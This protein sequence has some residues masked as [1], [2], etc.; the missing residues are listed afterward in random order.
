[1]IDQETDVRH[2]CIILADNPGAFVELC[3]ISALERL[4]RTLQRL[5]LTNA[6]LLSATPE[7]I[8]QRLQDAS[9][10]RAKVALEIRPRGT[11]PVTV[12]DVLDAWPNDEE[13]ILL[14]RGDRVFDSRLLQLLDEH[15]STAALVDSALPADLEPLVA[16]AQNTSCGYF[17]GAARLSQQWAKSH[18][19]V[20]DETLCREIENGRVGTLD[21]ASRRWPLASL[22]RELRPYWFPA[23]MPEKEKIAER[24]LLDAAQKGA[25]DFPAMIHAPIE[26][27][28]VSRLCQKE[29]TPNQLTAITNIV[30]WGATFF[31]A[32][33]RLALG[34]IL[35]LA[36]GVLDGL[37]GKLARVKIETSKA[38]KLEHWLDALFENS[39]WIALAWHFQATGQ[40]SGAFRYLFLL[41]GAEAIAALSKWSVIH[42]CGRTL[43]ELGEFNRIVR[44]IGARRNIHIWIFAL[45]VLFGIPDQAFKLMVWWELVTT[46]V[47]IPRA[48]LA[49]WFHGK[50]WAPGKDQIPVAVP[51]PDR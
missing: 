5:G 12:A 47:Q 33:G 3:G 9:P 51:D 36:V 32:T 48:A 43:D 22:R 38:G 24:V 26:N 15:D 50:I 42:I 41:L 1:L 44:F 2:Q 34:A 28:L 6:I 35:A 8:A 39:W 37:D 18:A 21:I 19:G 7:L 27:F 45:G 16:S 13:F 25:L 11:G 4:L 17:C 10:H 31:F 29:I 30:A 14:L 49:L 46:A 40:I 20:L 23:P